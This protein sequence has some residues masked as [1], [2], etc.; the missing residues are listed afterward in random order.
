[1]NSQLKF[2]NNDNFDIILIKSNNID[3]LEWFNENY[4]SNIIELDCYE[5]INANKDTFLEIVSN[6]L[7]L[8][9]FKDKTDLEVTTQIISEI[10]NYIYELVYVNELTEKDDIINN[11]ASLLNTN[12]NKVYGNAILM[13]TFIP[14]LS[15]SIL[16]K[17]ITISNIK[18]ILDSRVKT[19]IVIYDGEWSNKIV[20]G[21]I[22]EFAKIFFDEEFKKFETPFL[23]HNI[24]IWYEICD[25][26]S[27]KICGKILERPIYKCFWFTMITDEYRGSI[28]LDE[29]K[30]IIDVSNKM[31]F[32]FNAKK[33]WIDDEK[34]EFSRKVI[35]NKYKVLDIA[36]YELC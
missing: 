27:T 35:K 34:D 3:H 15:K 14:S 2:E 1:M 33:E 26:C 5:T 12:D 24:N 25:G 21:N 18:D 22:E 9:K 28:Y 20:I 13:K 11:I 17:N 4:T 10:P 16:I 36:H 7:N 8:E 31:N 19:N 23:L 32:P 29:V 6:K 30:K